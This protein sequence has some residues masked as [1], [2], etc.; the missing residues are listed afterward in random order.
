MNNKKTSYK[1]LSLDLDGTLLSPLLKRAKKADCL[2][3]QDYMSAG[4]MPFINTGRAPWAI[5]KT[6]QRINK[7][8]S[9]RIRLMSCWNGAYL[10]DF[11]DSEVIQT[12]ISHEYVKK[13]FEI[14]KKYKGVN[15]WFHTPE[16]LKSN[17]I[18]VYPFS[19]VIKIGYHLAHLRTLKDTK[20]LTSFK[21]DI[22]SPKKSVVAKIYHELIRHNLNHIVTISHSSPRLIEVTPS[23]INKG[24]AINYFA[25]KYNI[26]KNE[27]VSMGDSFNDLSAFKN[28]ALS[29]GINPKNPNL[30]EHCD[31]VVDHKT[32]G[33]KEA[34]NNYVIKDVDSSNCQ[35]IFTDLDGTLIDNRT[36]LFSKQVKVALQQCTNHLIPLAI[37]SGR[38]I[39][40]CIN[41]TDAMELNPK[42]NIYLIG[43]NGAVIYDIYTKKYLS[44]TPIED[45]DARKVFDTVKEFAKKVNDNLGLIIYPHSAQLM[46]YN[47]SF[48][49]PFNFKKTGFEDQYDPW[50]K[51]KPIYVTEYPKDIICYKF[52]IKFPD[53]KSAAA[54]NEQLRK[55]F[56]N[57]EICLSS[58]VNVEVNKKGVNKGF[59]AKK[60]FEQIKVNPDHVLVL[61]DGQNDIPALKLCKNSFVPSY[62]PDYVKKEANYVIDNVNVTN[63]AST[64]IYK[65]VLK[66][67][68]GK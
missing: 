51:T 18:F 9:N 13:I 7:M 34:I 24:Y 10:H 15:I 21:L 11:N 47:E 3:I 6:I 30:L 56:P 66:K 44:Q 42:T 58:T 8:G 35:L 43:D 27:I 61:G 25:K 38:G 23:K 31:A 39:Q 16:G 40:D 36:K 67:G 54:G 46:F 50:I 65:H 59:A 68:N 4:G 26:S 5:V 12:K 28:S 19:L 33:V 49:K 53:A 62:S 48:W 1:L 52:V 14:S 57:L 55:Q 37:A 63:F 64:V 17:T 29:I 41:I 2:A 45:E 20:D 60:L 22:F 32:R